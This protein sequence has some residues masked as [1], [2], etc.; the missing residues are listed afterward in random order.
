MK[1]TLLFIGFI[2][3]LSCK[4]DLVK[5][6][7]HRIEK[8]VMINIIYDLSILE[9]IKYQNPISIEKKK[10]NPT[11]YI[12]QKYKTDSL[13]FAQNNSYYASDFETY[14]EI[15]KAVNIRLDQN[16]VKIERTIKKEQALALRKKKSLLKKSKHSFHKFPDSLTV[17]K[18]KKQ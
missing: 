6:P 9:A 8:E 3:L 16:K 10:I 5:E 14:K 11:K 4:N 12:L 13:Q 2:V 7:K 17:P 1:K 15:Y 18:R